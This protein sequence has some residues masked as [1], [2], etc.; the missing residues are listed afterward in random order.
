MSMMIM[1]AAMWVVVSLAIALVV[2][3]SFGTDDPPELLGMDGD[4][5]VYR[6]ANGV[7]ERFPLVERTSH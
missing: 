4:L 3:G 6:R 1:V 2:G 5:A 7:I